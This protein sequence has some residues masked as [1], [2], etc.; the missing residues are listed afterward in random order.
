MEPMF[1]TAK[2]E[3]LNDLAVEVVRQ[4]AALGEKL[5]PLTRKGVVELIRTMNSYYSNL[6]EGH[7][8]H[9]ADIERAMASD[10]SQEP[11]KRALQ[12]ESV[13]HIDVQ[14][15]IEQK[16]VEKP[17]ESICSRTFLCWIHQEFYDRL[18]REFREIRTPDGDIKTVTPGKLREDEVEVGRHLPPASGA[19]VL[20]LQ[21]FKKC[22]G[23]TTRGEIRKVIA[24]AAAHHRLAWIHP[25]LDGNGRV[26]RLFTH[27]YLVKAR[28]DGHGLWTVS[29]GL[30]RNRNDY[31]GAL[32]GADERRH[33]DLDGRGNLSNKGLLDFCTFFLKTALDQISFMSERLELDGILRRLEGY[34]GRQV[35]FGQLPLEANYLLREAFLRGEVPR[36]E[37]ARITGKPDRTA[38]R[39]LKGL[40]E[41]KLLTSDSERAPVRLAF[42]TKVA[43]YYFP[44]LYPEGVE[45]T[46]TDGHY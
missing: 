16:L 46:E 18:P 43:G 38:R 5:H 24:A 36:G 4:S 37:V 2:S 44:Q 30:A 11:A 45:M 10:Y 3:E 13:A 32:A 8:T 7:N 33:G 34:V 31:M 28:I 17:D 39:T 40:L 27:A 23:N 26:T 25:F 9:P 20:F 21:R 42:P 29:R 35:S 19:L 22:Y 1:P 41:K 6:I 14:R 15:L 12:M